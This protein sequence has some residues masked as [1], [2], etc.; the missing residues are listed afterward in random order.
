MAAA[1]REDPIK[2]PDG[3]T[4]FLDRTAA[5]WPTA[6]SPEWNRTQRPLHTGRNALL[7]HYQYVPG[8]E[9]LNLNPDVIT[10]LPHTRNLMLKIN[11]A[12][13]P[14]QGRR[15]G[16]Y[17]D[18]YTGMRSEAE[19]LASISG[20]YERQGDRQPSDYPR[21]PQN[22]IRQY[23]TFPV[24]GPRG[25]GKYEISMLEYC[26]GLFWDKRRWFNLS[27]FDQQEHPEV[28]VPYIDEIDIWGIFKQLT[29][30]VSMLDSGNEVPQLH[31]WRSR[32]PPDWKMHEIC[33]YDIEPKN[34]KF[35]SQNLGMDVNAGYSFDWV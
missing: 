5:N 19:F 35:S 4:E 21:R 24:N 34:S 9:A 16:G 28:E 3:L 6:L 29:R 10:T 23:S 30:M 2:T 14:G 22:I 33:H 31:G 27:V 12:R 26:P 15:H 8:S 7:V 18:K 17:P 11:Y 20:F 25:L 13:K 1:P 32:Q